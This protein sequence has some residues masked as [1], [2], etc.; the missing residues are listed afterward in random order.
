MAKLYV[1]GIGGTGS[2][3]LRALA[4]LLAAGVKVGQQ[5]D[6]IVPIIVDPDTN[7]GDLNRTA[8]ILTKYQEI[9]KPFENEDCGFFNVK[10][11]TLSHLT[12]KSAQNIADN[13][14]FQINRTSSQ[15]FKNY[16]AYNSLS[17]INKDFID[18][19]FSNHNLDSEMDVGF[20]G[21]PNIGSVVLNQ[22]SESLEFHQFIESFG[23]NDKI[24][25]IS[26][27]FGG[28]GA[29]GFPLLLKNLREA[30]NSSAGNVPFVR[31]SIIGAIS[32]LPYFKLKASEGETSDINSSTF[33]GKAKAALS[34]YEGSIFKYNKINSFYYLGDH[35]GGMYDNFDGK[36][37]QKN[38]AH[39]LELA[40]AISILDFINDSS[41]LSTT[42][43]KADN[44]IY[45]EFG[46]EEEVNGRLAFKSLGKKSYSY[47]TKPLSQLTLFSYFIRF[48]LDKSKNANSPWIE[49][50][51]NGIPKSFF[52]SYYYENYFSEFIK[53]YD[54]WLAEMENNIPSFKP[55]KSNINYDNAFEFIDGFEPNKIIF[56]LVKDNSMKKMISNA[57]AL[58]EK[59][60]PLNNEARF[61]KLFYSVTEN[62]LVEKI[63]LISTK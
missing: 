18:L 3:V 60:S 55:F 20:K 27:I 59:F 63:S 44:P 53:Y 30:S 25:I 35:D 40:G 47:V 17:G 22:F 4:M 5:I 14:K 9:K 7:N 36:D 50:K 45:K 58:Y 24:F 16:I 8:D 52:N 62:T 46:V 15:K 56:G 28:T 19:I 13:F 51:K 34:Y 32:Y 29:A 23:Q 11:K 54:E 33:L 12:D 1:F 57:N 31:N 38:N 37:L 2:R 41:T 6:T 48:G 10:I 49:A 21:N 42:D 43:G 26:S 39:F 61:V